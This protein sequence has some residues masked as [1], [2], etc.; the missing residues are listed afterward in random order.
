MMQMNNRVGPKIEPMVYQTDFQEKLNSA[1]LL[2]NF[3]N[4]QS[5]YLIP[6]YSSKSETTSEIIHVRRS[7]PNY[8]KVYRGQQ[9][10]RF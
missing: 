3:L 4:K 2:N 7:N 8:T 9:N 1:P 10:R 6:Y 5:L